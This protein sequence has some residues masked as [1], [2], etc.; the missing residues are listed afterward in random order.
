MLSYNL[1]KSKFTVPYLY[2]QDENIIVSP[3]FLF[4]HFFG[5][6]YLR[7]FFQLIFIKSAMKGQKQR[8]KH[9]C[10]R[11]TQLVASHMSPEEG[12]ESGLQLRH[13]PLPGIEPGHVQAHAWNTSVCRPTL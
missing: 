5:N 9:G 8:E 13:V 3:L 2:F 6:T 7:I 1:F 4:C 12:Q 10:E 11:D